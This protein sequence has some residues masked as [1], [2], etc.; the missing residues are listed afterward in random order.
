MIRAIESGDPARVSALLDAGYPLDASLGVEGQ[1]PLADAVDEGQASVAKLLL[2]RGADVNLRRGGTSA[3]TVACLRGD[4]EMVRLLLSRGAEVRPRELYSAMGPARG[5]ILTLLKDAQARQERAAQAARSAAAQALAGSTSTLSAADV[6][7]YRLGQRPEDFALVVGVQDYMGA[8][9]ARFASADAAAMIR[10]LV[11][12]G[13][14]ERNIIVLSG[15]AAGRA[16]FDRYLERWLPGNVD[17]N[18]QVFFYF[19]GDGASDAAGRAYLLPWDGDAGQL[20]ATGYPLDRLYEKLGALKARRVVAL[21]D[22]SFDGGP[23]CAVA[24]PGKPDLSVGSHGEVSALLSQGPGALDEAR[25]HGALTLAVLEGLNGA[26]AG[27]TGAVTLRELYSY[28][29][30]RLP[31]TLLLSSPGSDPRLR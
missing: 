2:D 26:A 24:G 8:P 9:E 6:P 30:S 28:A 21:V 7:A 27:A 22:A 16:G 10:H 12:L 20:E 31:G 11:A 1:T 14:P 23:R 29:K 15:K 3:L 25:K 18:S 13:W 19:A 4:A 5:E 17:E